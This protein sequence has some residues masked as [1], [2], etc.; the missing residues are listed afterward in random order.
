[1]ALVLCCEDSTASLHGSRCWV[2]VGNNNC[3]A[4]LIRGD[5]NADIIAKLVA[6]FRR[7]ARRRDICVLVVAGEIGD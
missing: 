4:A 1:M 7:L 2:Y 3:L 6:R 5:S